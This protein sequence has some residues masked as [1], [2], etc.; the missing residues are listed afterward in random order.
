MGSWGHVPSGKFLTDEKCSD[1][2]SEAISNKSRAL[3][4]AWYAESFIQFL[5]YF[6]YYFFFEV[7][8]HCT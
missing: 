3:V 4:A 6:Y 8:M 5:F 1:I 7:H 2:A